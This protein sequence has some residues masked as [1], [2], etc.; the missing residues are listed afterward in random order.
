MVKIFISYAHEDRNT[1]LEIYNALKI[2]R[3]SPWIDAK[4]LLPGQ[5]WKAE[6]GKAIRESNI[7]V[8]CLS[9]YSQ[10]AWMTAKCRSIYRSGTGWI[11]S[12]KMKDSNSFKPSKCAASFLKT[13]PRQT[14][15]AF[16]SN[17]SSRNSPFPWKTS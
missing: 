13:F 11:T 15:S 2:K 6:I 4:D 7:F 8:A 14:L 16:L 10:S 12:M 9:N 3:L 5:E 17:Q 1:A